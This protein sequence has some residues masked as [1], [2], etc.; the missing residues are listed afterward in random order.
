MA[1]ARLAAAHRVVRAQRFEGPQSFAH[2]SLLGMVSAGRDRGDRAFEVEEL[3]RHIR[4]LIDVVRAIDPTAELVVRVSD[5]SGRF[6]EATAI[7]DALQEVEP[8]VDVRVD[9]DR[10]HGRGYYE[11]LCFKLGI[12]RNDDVVEVGDGGSTTWM[13]HLL[14]DRRST[15]NDTF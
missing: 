5:H 3:G 9:P 4:T 11:H 14:A 1:T 6:D 8:N 2:F 15:P 12:R 7:A 10:T 13:Q